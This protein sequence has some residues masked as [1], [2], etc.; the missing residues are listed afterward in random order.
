[1]NCSLSTRIFVSRTRNFIS[2]TR[3]F[4]S[5]MSNFAFKMINLSDLWLSVHFFPPLVEFSTV[6]ILEI[7][8]EE[9]ILRIH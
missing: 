8:D 4:V 3:N 6:W 7:Q 5:K 1:M 9:L 2:K